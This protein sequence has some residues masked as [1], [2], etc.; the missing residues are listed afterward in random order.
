MSRFNRISAILTETFRPSLLEILDE[1]HLHRGHHGHTG[2]DETHFCVTI[3]SAEFSGKSRVA[4][5]RLIHAALKAEL[6]SGL[7]AL[8][9]VISP[10]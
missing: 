8:R 3:S 6:D 1:S 10:S 9:I 7:H 2:R 4:V 5:H